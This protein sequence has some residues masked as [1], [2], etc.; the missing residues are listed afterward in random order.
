MASQPTILSIEAAPG[1]APRVFE[2][3]NGDILLTAAARPIV[4]QALLMALQALPPEQRAELSAVEDA[5]RLLGVV[6]VDTEKQALAA[7]LLKVRAI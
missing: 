1:D 3:F 7:N 4:E 6:R 5:M 2:Q